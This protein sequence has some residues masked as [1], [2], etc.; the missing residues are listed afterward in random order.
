MNSSGFSRLLRW[1]ASGITVTPAPGI[2][3]AISRAVPGGVS[4][5]PSPTTTRVGTSIRCRAPV[6]SVRA[7][8]A[9][10]APTIP[11]TG[12]A[13]IIARTV[14]TTSG[15][16][17]RVSGASTPGRKL[18]AYAP[19]PSVRSLR[20]AATRFSRPSS[21]SASLRVSQRTAARKRPGS[22]SMARR[23]T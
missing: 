21:V 7:A 20:M 18:S 17:S 2:R 1:P 5:S 3:R 23:R 22:R 11:S 4:S 15:R 19:R 10:C 16:A 14:A 12:F 8:M 9:I 13:S 6:V